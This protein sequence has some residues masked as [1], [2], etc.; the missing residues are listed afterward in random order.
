MIKDVVTVY[1]C[2]CKKNIIILDE[3]FQGTEIEREEILCPICGNE[4]VDECSRD[5]TIG[6]V[7]DDKDIWDKVLY[8]K[9]KVTID[10]SK[11]DKE[12]VSDIKFLLELF[13][14]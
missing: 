1:Q 4:M 3:N 13:D 5:M 9:N 10:K 14:E 12:L 7:R 8:I 11:L 2:E 6:S